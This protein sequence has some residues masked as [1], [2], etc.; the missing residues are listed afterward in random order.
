MSGAVTDCFEAPPRGVTILKIEKRA[1][2]FA[3]IDNRTL[4]DN[5]L[6]L[7]A[8]GLLTYLLSLP[9]DWRL[10]LQHLQK[11]TPDGRYSIRSALDE[12]QARGY[13]KLER[14]RNDRGRFGGSIWR[15]RERPFTEM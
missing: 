5:S 2:P 12:L 4:Q 3:R 7:K 1:D 14:P 13:A 9:A 8:R 10:S 6:S 15:I 11:I